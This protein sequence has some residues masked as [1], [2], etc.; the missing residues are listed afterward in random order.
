MQLKLEKAWGEALR[1]DSESYAFCLKE[2]GLRLR[3]YFMKCGQFSQ[4]HADDLT[5]E[6]LL[7]IHEKRHLFDTNQSLLPWVYAVA[8]Y[9]LIDCVRFEKR[10]PTFQAD[11]YSALQM[12]AEDSELRAS[13]FKQDLNQIMGGLDARSR[14]AVYLTHI[15]G[16]SSEEVARVMGLSVSNAKIIVHRAMHRLKGAVS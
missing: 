16:L 8:R 2:L 13:E 1:G 10:R 15:E 11:D 14:E 5:Q 9:R 3:R 4:S 7:S 6:T 12:G